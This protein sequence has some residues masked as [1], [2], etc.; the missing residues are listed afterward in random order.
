MLSTL[1]CVALILLLYN[2]SIKH[3]IQ[4]LSCTPSDSAVSSASVGDKDTFCCFLLFQK[5]GQDFHKHIEPLLDWQ[6][7]ISSIQVALVKCCI[8]FEKSDESILR[9][10]FRSI[11]PAR[12]FQQW[13]TC[14]QWFI[15]GE[16][17][18]LESIKTAGAKSGQVLHA[19]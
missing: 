3:F 12:Y 8:I 10:K 2:S 4:M 18:K 17:L 11:V 5:I 9:F 1:N 14:F 13:I 7:S 15:T 16:L 6:V 19:R